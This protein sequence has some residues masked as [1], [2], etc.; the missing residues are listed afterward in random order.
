MLYEKDKKTKIEDFGCLE[1][2]TIPYLAASPDGI[3][4]DPTSELY[5]RLLEIKNPVSR[6]NN[7]NSKEGLLDSNAIT[8]GNLHRFTRL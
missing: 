1:H 6:K 7:W 4:V 2:E 3:N 5:G 8:N